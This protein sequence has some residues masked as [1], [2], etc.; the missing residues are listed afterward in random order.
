MTKTN[1]FGAR[2]AFLHEKHNEPYT[3]YGDVSI[4]EK[5]ADI[6]QKAFQSSQLSWAAG[7]AGA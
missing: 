6:D 5:K 7:K 3:W 2:L 1:A 4:A